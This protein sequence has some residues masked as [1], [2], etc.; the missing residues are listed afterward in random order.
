MHRINTI[1]KL[2]K[3]CCSNNRSVFTICL[4]NI[5]TVSVCIK[6]YQVEETSVEGLVSSQLTLRQATSS[7]SGKY[8]CI[9]SNPFGRD[10]MAIHLSV[11]GN[12]NEKL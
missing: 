1:D 9:A 8:V 2:D 4:S 3:V 12:F 10:E 5:Y 11:R 7:D 6:R